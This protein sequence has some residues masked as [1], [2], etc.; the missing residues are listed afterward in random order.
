MNVWLLKASEPAPSP[1]VPEFRLMRAG[2]MARALVEARHEV[3]W[4]HSTFDHVQKKHL[5][6]EDTRVEVRPGW[7][8]YYLHGPAYRENLSLNR[9]RNG[10][11]IARRFLI[12]APELARPDIIV[13]ALPII[14]FSDAATKFGC[15]H[16]IPVVVDLRDMLPDIIPAH[17]PRLIRPL[18]RAALTPIYARAR[19]AVQRATALIGITDEFVDWGLRK[20]GRSRTV[21]DR[22]FPLAYPDK[23]PDRRQLEEAARFW[24]ARGLS[25]DRPVFTLCFTGSLGRQLDLHTVIEASRLLERAGHPHRLV[26]CGSGECESAYRQQACGLSSVVMAGWVDAVK[27]Y[28]LMRRS[29]VGLDPL[30]ARFDFLAT[31]NNKAIEYLSAGLPVLSCPREG[32]LFRFLRQADCGDSYDSDDSAGLAHLV[33]RLMDNRTRLQ[34]MSANARAVYQSSFVAE[35]VYREFVQYL[36]RLSASYVDLLRKQQLL[37]Q[38]DL[39]CRFR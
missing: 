9:L 38:H 34:A 3:V 30:P 2:L 14:E 21:L 33:A 1:A 19:R 17:F 12:H 27:L 6:D 15:L 8:I 25:S 29:H 5:Y 4:W 35:R 16:G 36:E 32:S 13:S 10:R 7:T 24:D 37:P 22:S 39:K 26:I 18:V 11:K 20:A 23:C 31:I 28:V